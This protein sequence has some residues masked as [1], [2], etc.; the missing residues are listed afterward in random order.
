MLARSVAPRAFGALDDSVFDLRNSCNPRF[1]KFFG[2]AG[3]RMAEILAVR[4]GL[5][6]PFGGITRIR[7]KGFV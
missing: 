4:L 2:C 5:L 7:F 1:I 3:K 6:T